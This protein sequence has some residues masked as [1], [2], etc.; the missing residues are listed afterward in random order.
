M[1]AFFAL[2]SIAPFVGFAAVIIGIIVW[3][4]VKVIH[5]FPESSRGIVIWAMSVVVTYLVIVGIPFT[6][7]IVI[8]EHRGLLVLVTLG[9]NLWC[10][11]LAHLAWQLFR[12]EPNASNF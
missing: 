10:F 2:G 1:E 9:A 4:A 8:P 5:L 3:V 12:R 6:L 11:G 7:A